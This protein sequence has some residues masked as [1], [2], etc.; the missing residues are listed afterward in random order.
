MSKDKCGY[1]LDDLVVDACESFD[2]DYDWGE[3][4]DNYD[5]DD[6][7]GLGG[8]LLIH[9]SDGDTIKL[10]QAKLLNGFQL[11]VDGN[12][13]NFPFDKGSPDAITYDMILQYALFG[14]VIYG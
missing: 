11:Y 3:D 7:I 8:E 2:S 10:T 6:V 14:E 9:A 1:N 13:K 4:G 5:A 12:G